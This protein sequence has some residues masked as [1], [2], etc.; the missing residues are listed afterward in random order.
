MQGLI[1]VR[2]TTYNQ[3]GEAVQVFVGNLVVP[4][5]SAATPGS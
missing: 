2:T 4:R 1:K 3:A 5:R